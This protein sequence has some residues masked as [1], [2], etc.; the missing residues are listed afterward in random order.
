VARV[1]A[2]G[3]QRFVSESQKGGLMKLQKTVFALVGI[4]LFFAG[5]LSAQQVKTDYDR[6]ANFSQY[7]SYSWEQVKTK[8]DLD[9]ARIKTAVNAALAAKGWTLV[10]SGGDVSIMAMEMT[11][12]QQSLN[13]FYDGFGGGWGWRR[14]G[15]GG[16]GEAT[17]TTETYKVGT[18][19]VDLFD[20]K[21][22]QLIWRASS[23]DTLSNNSDRNI[24]N[25]D[26]GVEKMF[27][28]FPPG[29]SK[30]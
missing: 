18:L 1:A 26:K 20:T 13:T 27:K 30:K 24:K 15:G 10:D 21:T 6:T 29:S 12:E 5:T 17:T 22:K 8:D 28:Q 2:A 7:K 14:F 4:I 3:V 23:S 9:V 11:R 25:L 19:V 16:F